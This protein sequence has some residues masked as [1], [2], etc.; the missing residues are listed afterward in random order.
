MK[1]VI[2]MLAL[3]LLLLP[4]AA[5]ANTVDFGCIGTTGV[6][7]CT[8]SVVTISGGNYGS[9]GINVFNTGNPYNSL[10]PFTL[11][12]NT[13]T[14][15]IS[16]TGTDVLTG[17]NLSGTIT[18]FS[19]FNGGGNTTLN[20]GSSWSVLP[21]SVQNALNSTSGLSSG[22]IHFEINLTDNNVVST[23][24]PISS[25]EPAS[26]GLMASGLLGLGAMFRRK[27]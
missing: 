21:V 5:M 4:A 9:T 3:A 23:D 16:L 22:S 14:Q 10:V 1:R 25:P 18:S 2:L 20:L 15:A 8:G 24:I 7:A 26:L 27:R 12:F 17:E 6:V 11:A 13:S 19:I